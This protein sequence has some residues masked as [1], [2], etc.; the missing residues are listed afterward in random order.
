VLAVSGS[1]ASM[2]GFAS[3]YAGTL[4]PTEFFS[5]DNVGRS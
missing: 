5:P 2:D 1:Q 4:P 3:L